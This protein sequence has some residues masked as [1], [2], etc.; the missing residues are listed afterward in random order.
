MDEI[1]DTL[2]EL[3]WEADGR[4]RIQPENCIMISLTHIEPHDVFS[5]RKSHT[6][7]LVENMYM[8]SGLSLNWKTGRDDE[9]KKNGKSWRR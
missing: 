3:V 1:N 2:W 9:H 4:K 8:L 5:K 6:F 7:L